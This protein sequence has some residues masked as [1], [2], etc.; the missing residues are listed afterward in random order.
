MNHDNSVALLKETENFLRKRRVVLQDFSLFS[1]GV[2]V[3]EGTT[4][5]DCQHQ[6]CFRIFCVAV[7]QG[8]RRIFI[9]EG[10]SLA[11][12]SSVG[13]SLWRPVALQQHS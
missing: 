10:I 12:V 11:Y 1:S 5:A 13:W 7:K 6:L 2:K 4:P 9:L 3:K 8:R